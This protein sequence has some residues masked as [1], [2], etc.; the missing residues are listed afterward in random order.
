MKEVLQTLSDIL[1]PLL[2]QNTP[3]IL[4]GL[5]AL[6]YTNDWKKIKNLAEEHCLNFAESAMNNEEKLNAAIDAVYNALPRK[7]KIFPAS[8]FVN[9]ETIKNLVN[10][11]YVTRVKPKR[12]IEGNNL[13]SKQIAVELTEIKEKIKRLPLRDSKG[14]FVKADE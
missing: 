12:D 11:V 13:S 8:L 1:V 2:I 5:T 4:A 7:F 14:R 6:W 10:L 9:T 3:E